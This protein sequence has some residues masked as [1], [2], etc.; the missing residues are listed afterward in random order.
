MARLLVVEYKPRRLI[1]AAAV[2]FALLLLAVVF[3]ATDAPAYLKV[4]VAVASLI[5]LGGALQSLI[6]GP[7]LSRALKRLS[8]SVRVEG[9]RLL[10][11][12]PLKLKPGTLTISYHRAESGYDYYTRL[13]FK[14]SGEGEVV[15]DSLGPDDFRGDVGILAG[16]P[17]EMAL[18]TMSST[19]PR[20]SR[21]TGEP[22]MTVWDAYEWIVA[23]A[24]EIVDPDYS[25]PGGS[26]LVAFI[27]RI[28][29]E[30]VLSKSALTVKGGG[31]TGTAEVRAKGGVVEGVLTYTKQPGASAREVRLEFEAVRKGLRH[32]VTLA[33]LSSPGRVSFRWSLGPEEEAYLLIPSKAKVRPRE[34]LRRLG[35][36]P[37]L[38]GIAW[39]DVERARL[40]LVLNIPLARDVVDEAWV[41]VKPIKPI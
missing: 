34:V 13:S 15:K 40:K 35:T 36:S 41:T 25:M 1:D 16:L 9:G 5:V 3:I 2:I 21:E 23:P 38:A 10:F 7:R 17:W 14:E 24:Y 30:I 4:L 19:A 8:G 26:I 37:L 39:R 33:R 18:D 11:P 32:R 31:A 6:Y 29:H 27:P 20:A 22:P 12:R 28:N